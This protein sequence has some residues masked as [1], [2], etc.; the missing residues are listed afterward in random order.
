MK[1][2]PYTYFSAISRTTLINDQ[3]TSIVNF[4]MFVF[5]GVLASKVA[6]H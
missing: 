6:V 2:M 5:E 4:F 1:T 3:R